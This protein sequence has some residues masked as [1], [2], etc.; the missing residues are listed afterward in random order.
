MTIV[1]SRFHSIQFLTAIFFII[2]TFTF[3]KMWKIFQY[4]ERYFAIFFV[5]GYISANTIVKVAP[6]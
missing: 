1:R 2:Y 6:V 5:Y 4:T 3:T